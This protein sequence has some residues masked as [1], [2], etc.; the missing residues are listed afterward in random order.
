[1]EVTTSFEGWKEL[2]DEFN[3]LI[4]NLGAEKVQPI[5]DKGAK[6]L[7]T[8]IKEKAPKGDTGNLKKGIKIIKLTRLADNPQSMLVKSTAPH[9]NIVEFGTKP[10]YQKNGRYTGS[11]P[12][13]PFFRPALDANKERIYRD[14]IESMKSLI[15]W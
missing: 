10:R 3:G 6:T 4:K 5:I 7:Q 15:T 2:S 12:A 9:D 13:N 14:M 8:A 11:M 1:M